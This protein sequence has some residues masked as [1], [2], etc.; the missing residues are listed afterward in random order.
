MLYHYNS[1]LESLNPLESKKEKGIVVLRE[2]ST[3]YTLFKTVSEIIALLSSTAFPFTWD[4]NLCYK[5]SVL[6]TRGREKYQDIN[7]RLRLK[8]SLLINTISVGSPAL[9]F[10]NLWFSSF[11]RLSLVT[12]SSNAAAVPRSGTSINRYKIN[13]SV[14]FIQS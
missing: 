12:G 1:G 10:N 13:A 2:A 6:R 7:E 8:M 9:P 11:V 4:L 5:S 3:I 14:R